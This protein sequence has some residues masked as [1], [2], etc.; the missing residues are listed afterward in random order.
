MD[1]MVKKISRA[2]MMLYSIVMAWMCA[3]PAYAA[4]GAAGSEQQI[5]LLVVLMGGVLII[6]LAVVISVVS[7]VVSTIA[8][9][10]DDE[11]E[12]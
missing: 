9:A 7:S 3:M 11:S 6:I 10:V 1:Q 12:D 4:N 5:G 2:M 8:S